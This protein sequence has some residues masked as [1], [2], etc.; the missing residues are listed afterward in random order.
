[1]SIT[2]EITVLQHILTENMVIS[3]SV[4]Y[5]CIPFFKYCEKKCAQDMKEKKS[6][7]ETILFLASA[8]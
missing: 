7:K 5:T 8:S 1:M 3:L 4:G 2:L 6:W